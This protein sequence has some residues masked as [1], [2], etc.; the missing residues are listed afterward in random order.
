MHSFMSA[1]IKIKQT[2][3]NIIVA[4]FDQNFL[5]HAD[6]NNYISA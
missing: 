2:G 3:H 4:L 1:N 5:A 6:F